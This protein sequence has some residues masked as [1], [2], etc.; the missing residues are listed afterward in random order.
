MGPTLKLHEA[1]DNV[2]ADKPYGMTAR[3]L[4]DEIKRRK[5][6]LKPSDGRPPLPGQINARVGNVTYRDRYAKDH[7][8]RITRL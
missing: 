8:G 5:L 6:F 3:E 7:L 1:I 2:L 4:A